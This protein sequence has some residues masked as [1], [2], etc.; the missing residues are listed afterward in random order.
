[1]V[2]AVVFVIVVFYS[3]N[4][5]DPALFWVVAYDRRLS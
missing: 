5:P 4:Y 2:I 3:V 1:M